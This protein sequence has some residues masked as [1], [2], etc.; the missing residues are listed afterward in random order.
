MRQEFMV[1]RR[2]QQLYPILSNEIQVMVGESKKHQ[3]NESL[4]TGSVRGA[5]N[6][7]TCTY[8]FFQQFLLY[9]GSRS[10][11]RWDDIS[12]F[13]KSETPVSQSLFHS[14]LPT[15]P[16]TSPLLLP[17]LLTHRSTQ[18]FFAHPFYMLKSF[19]CIS[20]GPL[21]HCA[22]TTTPLIGSVSPYMLNPPHITYR[23]QAFNF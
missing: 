13:G 19:Q 11:T 21:N 17:P 8:H 15:P 7:L 22:L 4:F 1:V 10:K 9:C 3:C 12:G 18:S 20:V 6:D 14:I 5:E 16:R 23:L 2:V